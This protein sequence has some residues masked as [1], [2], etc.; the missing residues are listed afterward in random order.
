MVA[1]NQ[2]GADIIL[3]TPACR[4]DLTDALIAGHLEHALRDNAP[5]Y[6]HQSSPGILVC[7]RGTEPIRSVSSD[8]SDVRESFD[9]M[10]DSWSPSEARG[11]EPH[12]SILR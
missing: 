10:H 4:Q 8:Q 9:V 6:R 3:G 1:A 12:H 11:R 2:N 5:G 7:A